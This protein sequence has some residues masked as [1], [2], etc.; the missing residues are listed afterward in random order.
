MAAQEKTQFD[1]CG[2]DGAVDVHAI[3]GDSHPRR[4]SLSDLS[5]ASGCQPRP[6]LSLSVDARDLPETLGRHSVAC[7]RRR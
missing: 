4:G 6:E 5:Q 2:V 3:L 7:S 1:S